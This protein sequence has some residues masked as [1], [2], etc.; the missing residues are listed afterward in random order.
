MRLLS[1]YIVPVRCAISDTYL[2]IRLHASPA[3]RNALDLG[4]YATA[5]LY[6]RNIP[7][8]ILA[9][10]AA[11]ELPLKDGGDRRAA[12]KSDHNRRPMY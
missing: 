6:S 5:V 11:T 1:Q 7:W 3:V 12:A 10:R 4:A 9:R 2:R 8:E